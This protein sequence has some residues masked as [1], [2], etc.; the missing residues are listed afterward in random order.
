MGRRKWK[1]L[2]VLAERDIRLGPDD[3]MASGL[4]TQVRERMVGTYRKVFAK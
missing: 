2:E 1:D 3:E 4:V